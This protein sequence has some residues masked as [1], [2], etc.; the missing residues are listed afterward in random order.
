MRETIRGHAWPGILHRDQHTPRFGWGGGDQ[1]LSRP[2]QDRA[3]C[4]DSVDDEIEDNL[5][6][7]YPISFDEWQTLQELAT[8]PEFCLCRRA[9]LLSFAAGELNHLADHLVYVHL[10]LAWRRFL[11]EL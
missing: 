4:L 10:V 6:Q 5:L 2:F 9:I 3:H 7:L 8:P 11:D 1:Q